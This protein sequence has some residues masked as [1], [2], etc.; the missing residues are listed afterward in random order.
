MIYGFSGPTLDVPTH[1]FNIDDF[2]KGWGVLAGGS[3]LDFYKTKRSADIA[4]Q[5]GY[6]FPQSPTLQT[7][8]RYIP[9][10]MIGLVLFGGIALFKR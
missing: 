8:D 5:Y 10:L 3:V 2:L 7:F 4:E 6:G 9:Y 1:G